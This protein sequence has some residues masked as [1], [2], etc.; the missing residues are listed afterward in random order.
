MAS[1]SFTITDHAI[2]RYLERVQGVDIRAVRREIACRVAL[3]ED[4]P[5]ASGVVSE[6]FRYKIVGDRVVTVIPASWIGRPCE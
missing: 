5:G 4:H 3:A 1:R 6:G 2:V